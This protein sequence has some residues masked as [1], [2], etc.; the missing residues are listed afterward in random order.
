MLYSV[1]EGRVSVKFV[2]V[3]CHTP[4]GSAMRLSNRG[5]LIMGG[6]SLLK[7]ALSRLFVS[8]SARFCSV[9]MC[10]RLMLRVRMWW[11]R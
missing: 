5:A 7:A 2:R 4:A 6:V 10:F 11:P 8:K 9:G 3:A 1:S